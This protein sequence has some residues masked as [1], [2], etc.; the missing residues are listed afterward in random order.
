M[1]ALCLALRPRAGEESMVL[2]LVP[3]STPLHR[4]A[5]QW[6]SLFQPP[7]EPPSSRRFLPT[8]KHLPSSSAIS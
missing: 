1:W 2:K 6:L 7:T 8:L 3:L 5:L 4:G